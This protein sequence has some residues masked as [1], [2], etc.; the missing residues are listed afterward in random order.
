MK[1]AVVTSYTEPLVVTDVAR[2]AAGP[3]QVVVRVRHSG[4]CHTDIHAARGDWPVKSI[5]PLI[6]GHEGVGEVVEVGPDV[7]TPTMG[8]IVAMPWLGRACGAC[9]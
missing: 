9:R 4:L 3:G 6:P 7:A 1:A 5:L 8:S 2:P